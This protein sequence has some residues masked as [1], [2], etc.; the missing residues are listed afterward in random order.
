M[1][2]SRRIFLFRDLPTMGIEPDFRLILV[3]NLR[4][5]PYVSFPNRKT[6]LESY[7]FGKNFLI[8]ETDYI[9]LPKKLAV[10]RTQIFNHP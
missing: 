7:C 9:L 4:P 5:Y 6:Y 3:N 1:N 8:T 2:A 10:L